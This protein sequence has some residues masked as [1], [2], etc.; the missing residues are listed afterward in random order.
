MANCISCGREIEEGKFFCPDCYSSMTPDGGTAPTPSTPTADKS[1]PA[2]TAPVKDAGAAA[3]VPSFTPPSEKRAIKKAP[4]LP[5]AKAGTARK[6]R[7]QGEKPA[8]RDKGEKPAKEPRPARQGPSRGETAGLAA[9]QA[10]DR[11]GQTGKRAGNWL[12]GL[13]QRS[14]RW[15]K[16]IALESKGDFDQADWI[17]WGVGTAASLLLITA[18]LLM[19]F[20]RLNWILT[21]SD[22][23]ETQATVLKGIDLGAWGYMFVAIS[24]I[25]TLLFILN[26]TVTRM[27]I[28]IRVN[29]A[30][31]AICLSLIELVVIFLALWNNGSILHAAANKNGWIGITEFDYASK[32]VMYGGYIAVAC[33]V[34]IFGAAA[35]RMAEREASPQW[36]KRITSW[37]RVKML[38]VGRSGKTRKGPDA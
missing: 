18:V 31:L 8:K 19:G 36:V 15:L 13:A 20:I 23:S 30:F 2:G 26:L 29:P 35:M 24:V 37:F 7:K 28:N 4:P 17:A 27:K 38:T 1:K 11:A 34:V 33:L 10:A 6:S 9:R 32:N 22:A 5:E 21:G 14:A 3:E 16:G 25:L 12:K